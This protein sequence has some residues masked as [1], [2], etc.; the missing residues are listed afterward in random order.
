MLSLSRSAIVL[1]V[2]FS[3]FSAAGQPLVQELEKYLAQVKTN[4]ATPI[5][6]QILTDFQNERPL[7]QALFRHANDA[8]EQFQFRILDLVRMIGTKSKDTQTRTMAVNHIVT[9]I[10]AKNLRVSGFASH[11]VSNFQKNDFSPL[12]K[13]SLLSYLRT[14][15]PNLD[16]LFKLVGYLEIAGAK[17]KISKMLIQPM[18]PTR[19]WNARLALARLGDE[20]A[21]DFILEKID[22]I[23]I[24]DQFVDSLV[25]GL[26][27]T[28]NHK[29]FKRLEAAL[30]SDS[31]FCA[32]ANP[33]SDKQ[34]LCAYRILESITPAIVNFPL[35]VDEEGDLLVDNYQSA[36]T[37]ARQWF[38][39]HS[40]YEINRATM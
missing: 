23:S 16:V 3:A 28:R 33:N 6:P 27:F 34:I 25:P 36:L 38:K 21:A 2:V 17:E 1:L 24:D 40:G 31:N 32:S 5:P 39:E 13:D 19:K 9:R 20:Q 18:S 22:A 8:D 15:I 37:T 11:A 12:S 30:Q 35:K 4:S 29:I 14:D 7:L 26:V 10:S